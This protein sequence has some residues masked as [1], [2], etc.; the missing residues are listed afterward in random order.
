[1][2]VV[3]SLTRNVYEWILPSIRS[4]AEHNPNARV[5][6]I[7]EDDA[8]P[9]A[10]PIRARVINISTQ[11]LFPNI[12]EHRTE[13][14]G[15]Y[16]N[17][18]KVYYPEILPCA[19]VIHLDIDT[20]VC[21]NLRKLWETNV[22]GKWFASVPEK[23]TW[24]KPYGPNYYNMG[25]SLINLHQ[26]RE[27]KISAEMGEYLRTAGRPFA[28]QDAWNKFGS[29]QDKAVTLPVRYNESIVTGKTD[30]PAIIHYC[31]IPDWW[32]NRKMDRVEYLDRY[33]GNI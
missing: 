13:A 17:H 30:D 27:D 21:G 4:L 15:G 18:L 3:Y 5:F 8:L 12:G 2:N 23:Q 6:I 7:S 28:D 24:Y 29:E 32:T 22:T 33:K 31:A 20:I 10:L 26:M 9:F 16:I 11:K 19:K 1:M 25:V 14:F